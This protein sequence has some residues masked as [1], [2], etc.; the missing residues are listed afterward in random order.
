MIRRPAMAALGVAAALLLSACSPTMEEV[1][2]GPSASAPVSAVPSPSLSPALEFAGQFDH[3]NDSVDPHDFIISAGEL[4]GQPCYQLDNEEYGVTV[5]VP[6]NGYE[7]QAVVLYQ[8]RQ[9][10]FEMPTF[11]L[12]YGTVSGS[13]SLSLEDLTGDGIPDLVYIYGGGGTGRWGD[14]AKVIDLTA[15]EE[16]P[17]TWDDAL[18][19]GAVQLQF[20]ALWE[21][22]DGN[23][24]AVYQ[25][26]GPD[27][28]TVYGGF[29]YGSDVP[30]S[31]ASV[32]T[33]GYIEHIALADGQL[34][35]SSAFSAG[36]SADPSLSGLGTLSA[37]FAYDPDAGSFS[38]VPD[39][40]LSLYEPVAADAVD[41]T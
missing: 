17:V 38:L 22:E 31:Q 41:G 23:P 30:P 28:E 7:V 11:L 21:D 2:P 39:F 34:V 8:G 19:E 12:G 9:T 1:S 36:L 32:F 16:R 10:T 18:L 13:A 33:H 35:L 25:V 5:L 3:Y 6:E 37:P 40:T 24:Q 4:D 14:Q 15:M 26:T 29:Y 27:G 20:A